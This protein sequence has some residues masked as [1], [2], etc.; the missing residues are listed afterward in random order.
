MTSL[1]LMTYDKRKYKTDVDLDKLDEIDTIVISVITGDEIA[2]VHY[3]D[4]HED[5]IDSDI[6]ADGKRFHDEFDG[7]YILYSDG[8]NRLEEFK[9]REDTYWWC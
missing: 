6:L 5:V 7:I 9:K 1:E 4:G 2:T 8:T 3:K